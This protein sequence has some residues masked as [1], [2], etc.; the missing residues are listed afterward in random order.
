MTVVSDAG[1]RA[2]ELGPPGDREGKRSQ[3]AERGAPDLIGTEAG[4]LEAGDVAAHRQVF[5]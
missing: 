2:G 5:A 3:W 4:G 1:S